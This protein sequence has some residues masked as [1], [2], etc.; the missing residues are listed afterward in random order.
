M[1]HDWLMGM[2]A[3]SPVMIITLKTN[4]NFGHTALVVI[5]TAGYALFQTAK[6]NAVMTD[7][8]PD[9]RMMY[10]PSE[11]CYLSAASPLVANWATS[12]INLNPV[13][14]APSSIVKSLECTPSL[15]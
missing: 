2:A 1:N 12:V 14:R 8:R 6:N 10:R 13:L 15:P 3:G 11:L 5:I 7:I 9:R 4:A